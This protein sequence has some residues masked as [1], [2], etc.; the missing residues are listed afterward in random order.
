MKYAIWDKE[1]K[2][3]TPAGTVY[4]AEEWMEKY[5]AAR[6]P[7]IAYVC[8]A[9]KINGAFFAALEMLA[10]QCE[11]AGCDF[12]ECETDE[13]KLEAIMA[14]EEQRREEEAAAAENAASTSER[15]ADAM[16]DM[17]VLAMPDD[18]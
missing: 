10:A 1:S 2:V 9:G 12:S 7:D 4:T 15:I 14:F 17:V 16:E 3:Y 18:I 13:E 5:P 11:E 8:S 6:D